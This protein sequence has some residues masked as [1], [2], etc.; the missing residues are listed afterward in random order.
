[1]PAAPVEEQIVGDEMPLGHAP[2]RTDC[3]GVEVLPLRVDRPTPL[4]TGDQP[5]AAVPI[6]QVAKTLVNE[7]LE[8]HRPTVIVVN[9][10]DLA[11]KDHTQDEYVKYLDKDLQGLSLAPTV[12]TSADRCEGMP[13][14]F[15]AATHP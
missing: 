1:M 11:E 4:L 12:L 2:P 6:S 10:W 5:D 9:K 7:V 3:S 13:D 8:H 14:S 15:G